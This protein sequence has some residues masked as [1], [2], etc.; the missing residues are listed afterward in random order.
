[1]S[2]NSIVVLL[3]AHQN[4]P[5]HPFSS[6]QLYIVRVETKGTI[7]CVDIKEKDPHITPQLAGH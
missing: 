4:D 3:K 1:M 7:H 5:P 2:R 6:D